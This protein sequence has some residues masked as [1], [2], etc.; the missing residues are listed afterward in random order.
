MIFRVELSR[1]AA[2]AFE[3][4]PRPERRRVEKAIDTLARNP[5][6]PGKLVKA[7]QGS[8]DSFLRMRVGN[9]RIMYEVADANQA[10]LILGI[11]H[12]KD[13]EEWLRQHR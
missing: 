1:S 13:L 5:R 10:V 7:I 4:S 11:I 6:P 2:R 8:K 9:Y 3:R 12:R